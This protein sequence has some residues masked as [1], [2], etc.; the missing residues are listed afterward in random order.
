[1]PHTRAHGFSI[2]ESLVALALMAS[3]SAALLPAVAAAA[4]LQRAAAIESEAALLA[5][6]RLAVLKREIADGLIATREGTGV[7]GAFD[8][9]WWVEASAVPGILLVRVRV[10]PRAGHAPAVIV[11]TAVPDA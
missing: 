3:V 11:S 2:V 5:A 8:L 7:S 6:G 9:R 10:V 1:M 4:R